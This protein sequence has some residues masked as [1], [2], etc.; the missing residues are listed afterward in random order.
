ME[1]FRLVNA[2][3]QIA[4]NKSEKAVNRPTALRKIFIQ[5][6]RDWKNGGVFLGWKRGEI[7][8]VLQS[9]SL[10][11]LKSEWGDVGYYLSQSYDFLWE[12]Y[13]FITPIEIIISACEK[14]EKRAEKGRLK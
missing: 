7:F 6:K 5:E 3:N 8:E 4:K 12:I 14:F 11:E 10:D 13:F 1:R 2:A 9:K